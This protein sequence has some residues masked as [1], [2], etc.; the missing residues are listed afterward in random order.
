MYGKLDPTGL[1]YQA[2]LKTDNQIRVRVAN[3]GE[4]AMIVDSVGLN[5][6][7]GN[8]HNIAVTYDGSADA[9]G[10]K[11]YVDGNP[12]SLTIVTNA[13]SGTMLNN[14]SLV[15]GE[16]RAGAGYIFTGQMDDFRVYNSELSSNDVTDLYAGKQINKSSVT[17]PAILG[18][19]DVT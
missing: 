10:I 6:R 7:D 19:S 12:A 16:Q 9:A 1:G 3:A 13:F 5:V 2:F 8:W 14:Q 15:I 11:L 17:N 18:L 4:S